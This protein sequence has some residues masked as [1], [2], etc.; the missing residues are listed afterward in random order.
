[1]NVRV[2]PIVLADD[3]N[4]K[5]RPQRRSVLPPSLPPRGLSRRQAAEYIGVSPSHFDK[6][7]RDR[8]MPPAKRLGGRA[9]WDLEQLDRAFNALDAESAWT[10]DDAADANSWDQ[11]FHRAGETQIHKR[12]R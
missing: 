9:V 4:L 11:S 12:G 7:V 5:D 2:S 8:V 6:L 1:M 10:D 3:A